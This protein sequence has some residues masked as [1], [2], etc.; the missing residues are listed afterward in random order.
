MSHPQNARENYNVKTD[1]R[2]F[3][4]VAQFKYLGTVVTLQNLIQ[5]EIKR[6]F[7]SGNVCNHSV[8]KLI[9]S[10]MLSKKLKI[11]IYKAVILPGFVW[12]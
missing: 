8:Q 6:R 1:N 12:V 5:K 10:H 4:N 2:V 3:K 7:N 9:S 11:R